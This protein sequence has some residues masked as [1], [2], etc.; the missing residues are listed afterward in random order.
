MKI[1]SS[2]LKVELGYL[3]DNLIE[4]I[5]DGKTTLVKDGLAM[6]EEL[7]LAFIEK[8][9]QWGATYDRKR[10]IQEFG[11]F[12]ESWAEIDW[13]QEDLREVI[14]AS[15]ASSNT[16]IIRIVSAFP[17]NVA[18]LA[19]T[20]KEYFLFHIFINWIPDFYRS[21]VGLQKPSIQNLFVEKTWRRLHEFTDFL[22]GSDIDRSTSEEEIKRSNE[23]GVGI[24]LLFNR[25]LKC[26]FDLRQHE[27]FS[28]FVTTLR[29]LFKHHDAD[30]SSSHI[31]RLEFMLERAPT[32]NQCS[33][34][35]ELELKK[36]LYAST[37]V[38]NRTK[39]LTLFGIDA[40][41]VHAFRAH[42]MTPDDFMLWHSKIPVT[43]SPSEMWG[44]YVSARDHQ[45]E[46][47]FGW[48]WWELDERHVRGELITAG[49]HISFDRELDVLF[50][51]RMLE[52]LATHSGSLRLPIASDT[53]YLAE[54]VDSPLLSAINSIKHA[55]EQWQKAVGARPLEA[56]AK[57][58]TLLVDAVNKAKDKK[59][60]ELIAAAVD[61]LKVEAVKRNILKAWK[62]EGDARYL[63]ETFGDYRIIDS[64]PENDTFY[65][66]N[67]IDRKDVYAKGS[68]M[69][70]HDYGK[71]YG[72]G[73]G[74]GETK[75]VFDTILEC[76]LP[77]ES[78]PIADSHLISNIDKALNNLKSNG[79]KPII[80]VI[81]SWD[82]S[83]ILERS[84]NFIYYQNT[85][86]Q[87]KALGTYRD[88]PVF[89]L[90]HRLKP[91]ILIADLKSL[92]TWEQYRPHLSSEEEKYLTDIATIYVKP[93]TLETANELIEKQPNLRRGENG[94]ERP[95]Q[96]VIT[97]LQQRVHFRIVEH[98]KFQVM[99]TKA[100]YKLLIRD[101][102]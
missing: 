76:V 1:N 74:E 85:P 29:A 22:I 33:L 88:R 92:G 81:D 72:E 24:V 9:K 7:L 6:Y 77:F 60:E 8:L 53:Y 65:G 25:L 62:E 95:T 5:N 3:R 96:E 10:A 28:V 35:K 30:V 32:Q 101:E 61:P 91:T 93:Y 47:D 15:V 90:R 4:A 20:E 66:F 94:Q 52:V 97:E 64:T 58:E 31:K 46:K 48:H 16:S 45:V 68:G 44:I 55:K 42:S 50:S 26:S 40:W 19:F 34:R 18:S 82:A 78:D 21:I 69:N 63:I 98:F 89:Q 37:Q 79:Y 99:D 27:D 13:I 43:A 71:Q 11:S 83:R 51:I 2:D 17:I 100:G 87:P 84:D 39:Q 36:A 14:N 75:I 102:Q 23:F 57:L 86:V 56:I 80:V 12:A 41:I 59:T 49:T 38:L 73:L 70:V 67:L 54:R